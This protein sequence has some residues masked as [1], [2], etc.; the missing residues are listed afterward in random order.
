M[1][2]PLV[3]TAGADEQQLRAQHVQHA[4]IVRADPGAPLERVGETASG[5][6]AN[7]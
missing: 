5:R 4:A 3:A 2:T 6:A 1:L 7:P